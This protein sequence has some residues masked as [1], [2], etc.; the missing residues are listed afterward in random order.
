MHMIDL[1]EKKKQGYPLLKNEIDY[2]ISQYTDGKIPDYQVSALLMAIC[3]NGMNDEEVIALTQAMV[4]SG[5]QIDLSSISGIKVDKHSTGGVGDKVT[6]ILAP[7]LASVGIPVAKMSGRGLGHTGGTIDKLESI[8]GFNSEQ[9]I[10][11]FI[12]QVKSIGL[13]VI[14]QSNQLVLADKLL[15]A[16]RD[17]T[18]TVDSIPLIASSIMSKKIAAGSNAILLD[19]TVGSGAFMKNEEDADELAKLMVKLG[20]KVGLKTVAVL[21]DMSE[22]LGLAIGNRLEILEAVDIL[23]N[24]GLIELRD[25]V[26]DLAE[27][28]MSLAS[29]KPNRTQLAENLRNGLAYR[30]FVEMIEAQGGSEQALIKPSKVTIKEEY[31]AKKSGVIAKMDALLL[32]QIAMHIGAGRQEKTDKIDFEV[33]ILLAKKVGDTVE[34]GE[35]LLTLYANH[36]LSEEIFNMLERAISIKDKAIQNKSIIKTIESK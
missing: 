26:L 3:L 30:K 11:S 8:E 23:Q 15:Y 31:F 7:L 2:W 14:G 16:L 22:P 5:K 6:L 18:A 34:K 1:I 33:G 19:V 17:V 36:L 25:F 9:N 32:G 29:L 35:L 10:T 13:S 28:M 4:L 21:T 12:Q 27:I 24:K 20:E